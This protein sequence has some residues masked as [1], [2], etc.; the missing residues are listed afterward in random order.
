MGLIVEAP[1]K[2]VY[3]VSKDVDAIVE[4]GVVGTEKGATTVGFDYD[5]NAPLAQEA[6]L[7]KEFVVLLDEV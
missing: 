4:Y 3:L 7:R 5:I 2:Q 6:D 1:K